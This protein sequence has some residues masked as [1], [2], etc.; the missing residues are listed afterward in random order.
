ME[1]GVSIAI[2]ILA[3]TFPSVVSG[4]FFLASYALLFTS[5]MDQHY[6]YFVGLIVTS[7]QLVAV[8]GIIIYKKSQF[9]KLPTEFPCDAA[10]PDKCYEDFKTWY[11]FTSDMG[12]DPIVDPE[13]HYMDESNFKRGDFQKDGFVMEF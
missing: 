10:T 13:K 11:K 3:M 9:A 7:I 6:R 4:A 5:T 2:I 12:F 1:L 8:V